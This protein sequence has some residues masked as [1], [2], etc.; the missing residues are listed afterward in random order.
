MICPLC[1][2][3]EA[4]PFHRD[5]A[6]SYWRCG[7]CALLFVPPSSWVDSAAERARYDK[8]RNVPF[9]PGYCRFLSRLAEPLIQHVAAGS[10]GLDFGCGPGPALA[11][12]LE[13]KG[14][15]VRLYDPFYA[16][17]ATVWQTR[18]DFITATEVVEHL[19]EPAV[20]LDRLFGALRPGGCLGLM[21]K[22][23]DDERWFTQSRYIRD[24]THIAFYR[25]DTMRWIADHWSA[26]LH[27]PAAD[28]ALFET[29]N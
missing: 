25:A 10:Q 29:A 15:Q 19:R 4:K 26:T 18:Y 17:D 23:V 20:E 27:I 12:L 24:P 21:T 8:H 6:R 11:R 13:A 7:R 9:D 14:L 1:T 16:N 5:R 2:D 3:I 22:W 28:I